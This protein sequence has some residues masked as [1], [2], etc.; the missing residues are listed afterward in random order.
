MYIL[1]SQPTEKLKTKA[2]KIFWG[3]KE[4]KKE[5]YCV[6][7]TSSTVHRGASFGSLCKSK[8]CSGVWH[9]IRTTRWKP[10]N[11]RV[12]FWCWSWGS[13]R[14]GRDFFHHLSSFCKL[15]CSSVTKPHP[16][17]CDPI[18]CS[19][20]GPPCP[21]PTPRVYSNSYPLSWWCHPA[22]PSS[23]TRFLPPSIFPSIRVFPNEL[24]LRIR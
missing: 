21:S 2:N 4:E 17:V 20:P 13:H 23:V 12:I 9:T 24:A 6:C 22:I 8:P 11:A 5:N 16:T 1:Q 7:V 14:I 10:G 18:D 19:T 15:C 3:K